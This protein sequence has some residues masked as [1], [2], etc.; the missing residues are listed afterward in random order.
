[1]FT[2][3]FPGKVNS[4]SHYS[5]IIY[6]H[7]LS[8]FEAVEKDA[9]KFSDEL[10]GKDQISKRAKQFARLLRDTPITITP[11]CDELDLDPPSLTKKWNG[12]KVRYNFDFKPDSLG[13]ELLFFRISIQV[14][15]IEIAHIKCSIEVADIQQEPHILTDEV[16]LDN[17]L[18]ATKFDIQTSSMY[19]KIFISYSRS[20]K[21]VVETYR[22]AQLALGNE[23]FMDTYSIRTGENW[24]KAL[25][26]AIDEAD[27]F[28]LFWSHNSAVSDNVRDEWDYALKYKC[29]KTLCA[30]FIRPVFWIDPMPAKPPIELAHLHFRY[31]PLK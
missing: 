4:G 25:A 28:Q 8:T 26:R 27:I 10:G 11:E 15:G 6:A 9:Q 29:P 19:Q 14:S 13:G 24:R 30:S 2:T 18:A 1:L 22:K 23:V 16:K 20:D 7:L 3:Y 17:P 12:E 5:L 21:E 31:V